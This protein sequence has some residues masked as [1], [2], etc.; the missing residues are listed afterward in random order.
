MRSANIIISIVLLGVAGFYAYLIANLPTR[1]LP[2]T[3]GAAFVPS[4]LAGFLA[5]LSITLLI[6]SVVKKDDSA[7]VQLPIR[8]L[9]GIA[10]LLALI[11]L[12]V[13]VMQYL[14]FVFASIVFLGVLT[15]VAGTKKPVEIAV[16]SITTSVAVY[17]LFHKFFNVQLPTGIF[18]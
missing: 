7:T 5:L 1:D 18:N 2:N 3:L 10:G 14:G 12:Y 4:V 17:L 9:L 13:K 8:E 15:C 16:F 6:S 11:A